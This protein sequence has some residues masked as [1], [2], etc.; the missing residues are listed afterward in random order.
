MKMLIMRSSPHCIGTNNLV[1]TGL[2]SKFGDRRIMPLL[3]IVHLQ[4]LKF[5]T[6]VAVISQA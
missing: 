3:P 1:T 6:S 4:V 5:V 2:G